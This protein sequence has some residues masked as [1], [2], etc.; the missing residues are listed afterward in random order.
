[1]PITKNKIYKDVVIE[2]TP[3]PISQVFGNEE[4]VDQP[5][6]VKTNL[7]A[8]EDGTDYARVLA[9]GVDK[10]VII[11]PDAVYQI[12]FQAS[13]PSADMK[14][15]DYWIDSDDNKMYR[16]S[17]VAWVE[18]QDDAIATAIANAADAQST[19]D[20]KIKTFVQASAPTAVSVGD[21][22][23]DTDDNN[24]IYRWSDTAWVDYVQDFATW[25]KIVGTGKAADNATVN[26]IFAQTSAP[27]ALAIGDIWF[28]TDD[29]N[30]P[31]RWNGTAWVLVQDLLAAL[32]AEANFPSDANLVGYWAFDEG[33]GAIAY[34]NS[35]NG[36]IG[37]ING[38][39]VWTSGVSGKAL[40]FDGT[41]DY[42]DCGTGLGTVMGNGVTNISVNFWFKADV[43][44][45][46]D[47][48]FT[49]GN[50]ADSQGE[51][52]IGIYSNQ[53]ICRIHNNVAEITEAFTD[54]ASWHHLVFT[55]N[56]TTMR[57]Y[58]DGVEV[59]IGTVSTVFDLNGLK[60][61]I[62]GYFSSSYTFNGKMTEVRV[63]SSVLTP[64]QVYALY[65][66]PSGNPV[67]AYA[68]EQIIDE[69]IKA[70]KI[71]TTTLSAI[72]ANLGTITAGNITLDTSGFIR[73]G[74]T[75]F[76]TGDNGFWFGYDNGVWKFSMAATATQRLILDNIGIT[77]LGQVN[78]LVGDILYQSADTEGTSPH[79]NLS[80]A[81]QKEIQIFQPGSYR[82]KFAIRI[83]PGGD[84]GSVYGKI[85]KNGIAIGTERINST[86]TYVTYSEDISNFISGD[87]I[88]LYCYKTGTGATSYQRKEFRLYVSQRD[89]SVV[90]LD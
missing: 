41:G 9:N 51:L 58:L 87:L 52:M 25:N 43:T 30:K 79:S 84:A 37:T 29:N 22:W 1:M 68:G 26:A 56:G 16:Y 65:K 89:Y 55:Y 71:S 75:A 45:G 8:V 61:I 11:L 76:D 63:Y 80:Y 38:N 39:P 2:A 66:Y 57:L 31:Y 40:D 59:E 19:A 35:G 47:G 78:K 67:V 5:F 6:P 62:G 15:G 70:A 17:G 88:Q 27:T 54:T 49:I 44:D 53:I 7:D 10:G 46:D 64:A 48:L 28:D 21:L 86:M 4:V 90:N 34:D 18:I 36:Y 73:G 83:Y 50:F 33:T 82:I 60:T 12:F 32:G 42:V 3:F 74:Q 85:Y 77:I 72:V 23:M 69:T 24:R 81:K 20:G 14:T 13:A